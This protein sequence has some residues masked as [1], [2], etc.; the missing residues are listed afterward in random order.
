[1]A[2]GGKNEKPWQGIQTPGLIIFTNII[3]GGTIRQGRVVLRISISFQT[4]LVLSY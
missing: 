4:C 3:L 2:Q 1:M